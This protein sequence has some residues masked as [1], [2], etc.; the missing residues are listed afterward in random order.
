M[1]SLAEGDGGVGEGMERLATD[2]SSAFRLFTLRVAGV[3][4]AM[5]YS[6]RRVLAR[7]GPAQA[8]AGDTQVALVRGFVTALTPPSQ[9]VRCPRN[10]GNSRRIL[11][12]ST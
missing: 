6:G 4:P 9:M 8:A 3:L 2:R 5:G 7:R 12:M 11:T 10:R 1:A